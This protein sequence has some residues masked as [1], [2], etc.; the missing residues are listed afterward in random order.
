M[1]VPG[2]EDSATAWRGLSKMTAADVLPGALKRCQ[3]RP[4]SAVSQVDA[5]EE[6]PE[7][8]PGGSNRVTAPWS[9]SPN[10]IVARIGVG[11]GVAVDAVAGEVGGVEW[12]RS[13]S[14]RR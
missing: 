2:G 13:G 8:T 12:P 6:T 1:L 11:R 9:A 10:E 4:P 3:V 14:G 7:E 5:G